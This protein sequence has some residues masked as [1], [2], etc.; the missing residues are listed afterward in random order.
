MN[1][2]ALK[3]LRQVKDK[4]V[5]PKEK[6]IDYGEET[7]ESEFYASNGELI[8]RNEIVIRLLSKVA[9]IVDQF[10]EYNVI[11]KLL[12]ET[13][14]YVHMFV[15]GEHI[16]EARRNLKLAQRAKAW[17]KSKTKKDYLSDGVQKRYVDAFNEH[18]NAAVMELNKDTSKRRGSYFHTLKNTVFEDL[19][20]DLP[21]SKTT[22]IRA[23][24]V[25]VFLH[26]GAK[27][28]PKKKVEQVQDNLYLI[29]DARLLGVNRKVR[30]KFADIEKTAVNKAGCT[31]FSRVIP[32]AGS[33]IDWYLLL[34]FN[35]EITNVSFVSSMQLPGQAI[36]S[37][38]LAGMSLEHYAW[39]AK[40]QQEQRKKIATRI[41]RELRETFE[42]EEQ[43]SYAM[44]RYL[45]NLYEVYSE[46]E[47][48]WRIEFGQLTSSD[49][50]VENGLE[51]SQYSKLEHFFDKYLEDR[52]SE[53]DATNQ[54]RLDIL[55]ERVDA[56]YA[57]YC[58]QNVRRR[59]QD[60]RAQ[61]KTIKR[62]IEERRAAMA[63]SFGSVSRM[64]DESVRNN[65]KLLEVADV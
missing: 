46:A 2:H 17:E 9:S 24:P 27:I 62:D 7:L 49:G 19:P 35:A 28:S 30:I 44:L 61:I 38:D 65:P 55:Q 60:I 4:F 42:K 43:D 5:P 52:M 32:K 51:P 63:E 64:V 48:Y 56:R 37:H 8:R 47:D 40:K 26:A 53:H 31:V 25:L 58:Y 16:R 59:L 22:I 18:I 13:S 6:V 3:D 57:Y 34:D 11:S 33:Q 23:A 45:R 12:T 21:K 10:T 54:T 20:V 41:Q 50:S 1:A 36:N 15:V 14:P 39:L 29:H